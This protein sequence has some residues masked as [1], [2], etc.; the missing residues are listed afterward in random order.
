VV[1]SIT[2]TSREELAAVKIQALQRAHATRKQKPTA[3][4]TTLNQQGATTK[5]PTL[6]LA[7]RQAGE[8]LQT[9]KR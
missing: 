8:T 7:Q 3:V 5:T 6:Q 2:M 4:D 9:E 1:V